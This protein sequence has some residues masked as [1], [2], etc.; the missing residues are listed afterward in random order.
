MNAKTYSLQEQAQIAKE[1]LM[2]HGVVAFPTETVMGLGV[3]FGRSLW[4]LQD[5]GTSFHI[6]GPLK[7]EIKP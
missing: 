4:K 3:L 2:N 7:N 1:R 6:V 5:L